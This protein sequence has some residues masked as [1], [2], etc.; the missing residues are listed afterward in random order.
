[1]LQDR[2]VAHRGFRNRYPENTLLAF[3][4]AVE[5]GARFVETDIMLSADLQPVLYHDPDLQRVSGRRGAVQ[6]KLLAELVALPAHEPQRFGNRF[7]SETIA[8]LNA[9]ADWLHGHPWVTAF[10]EIKTE[11]VDFAGAE[12]VY[13]AVSNALAKFAHQCVLI[14]FDYAFMTHVR[15][16]GW[17]H[18]GVVL[19][20][21][22]DLVG[23]EVNASK[24]DYIFCDARKV[25]HR[26]DIAA[27]AATT[28]LYETADPEEAIAW[29]RRG[30]D[31]VETFDIGGMIDTL[32][33]RAL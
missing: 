33:H 17:R 20:R 23:G 24:P 6:S 13:Q 31:M 8:P 16:A 18:C 12:R 4:R 32:A 9:F 21:W 22:E 28:V 19:A 10:V 27:I 30:A 25:P 14:S 29:F 11:A 2:L 1:M 7:A 15:G 5:S 26:A 3:T